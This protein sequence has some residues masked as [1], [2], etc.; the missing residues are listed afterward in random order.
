VIDELLRKEGFWSMPGP[1]N[2][3]VL[4][5]RIR[6]ARNMDIC[7]SAEQ[8]S[9]LG[10]I[11]QS[12]DRFLNESVYGGKCSLIDLRELDYFEK[13][14]LRE[15]NVISL[16]MEE[17]DKSYI[18]VNPEDDFVILVNDD[19]TFRIQVI[20]PGLQF[21]ETYGIA[22][23]VDNELNRIIPY[24]FSDELG[25]LTTSPAN[26]GTGLKASCLVHLPV[27]AFMNRIK[28]LTSDF[29]KNGVNISATVSK[30][31]APGDIYQMSNRA[32]LGV[33]EVDIIGHMD[34]M[35]NRVIDIED[36]ERDR[37]IS[38]SRLDLEDRVWRSYG[39]LL[40]SRRISYLEALEHL[41][42]IRLGIVLAIIRDKEINLINELM[43]SIQ[44]SHLQ[45]IYDRFF[46]NSA[47]CD[48]YRAEHMKYRLR[49]QKE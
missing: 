40:F 26:L 18:I 43:V 47:E 30:N 13:R 48:E 23:E 3:I 14:L 46:L 36:S 12:I 49:D 9:G 24:A 7:F 35:V 32:T 19:D 45:R 31:R 38:E 34:C 28:E 1:R 6:L 20:R 33:S 17:S 2:D 16:E 11:R 37:L 8:D 5:S 4:S 25:Y 41:S 42:N 21:L 27:S 44:W 15:R 10:I 39:I 29:S 22:D